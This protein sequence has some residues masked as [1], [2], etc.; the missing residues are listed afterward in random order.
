MLVKYSEEVAMMEESD[1]EWYEGCCRR[2]KTQMIYVTLASR[3]EFLEE[4]DEREERKSLGLVKSTD[5]SNAADSK[6]LWKLMNREEWH[7]LVH[8]YER[9]QD[10]YSKLG[11]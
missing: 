2:C 6:V 5:R 9:W 11:I 3:E 10:I 7:A 4:G 8:N 1:V